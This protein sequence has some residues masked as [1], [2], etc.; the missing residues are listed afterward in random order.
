[1]VIGAIKALQERR[2]KIEK[3]KIVD[4]EGKVLEGGYDLTKE[5]DA[6]IEK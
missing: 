4:A 6:T 5:I 3:G 2:V 1:M